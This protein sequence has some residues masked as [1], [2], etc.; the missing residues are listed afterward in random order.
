MYDPVMVEPMRRELV[1]AGVKE[2]KTAEEVDKAL[3]QPSTT[4]VVVNSVCGCA[5]GGARPGVIK[6]IQ[7]SKKPTQITTVFAGQDKDATERARSYFLGYPPSSPSVAL[8][9]DGEVVFMLQRKDIEGFSADQ[10]S[11]KLTAAFDLYC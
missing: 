10:I 2:L 1:Q 11:E 6:A 8:L 9:K 3:S 4:L 5:A 7:H